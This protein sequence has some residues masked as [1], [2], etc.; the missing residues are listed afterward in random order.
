MWVKSLK[1]PTLSYNNEI[2]VHFFNTFKHQPGWEIYQFVDII[3]IKM[4]T[5]KMNYTPFY[6]IGKS[7]L[8]QFFL[9]NLKI[10]NLKHYIGHNLSLQFVNPS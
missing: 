3:D 10:L 7:I 4:K 6:C 1:K 5:T 8:T 9:G 2:S